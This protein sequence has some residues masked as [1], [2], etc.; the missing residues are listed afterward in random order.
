MR[1][2][3]LSAYDAASHR[4][5]REGLVANFPE[6]EWRVLSLPPRFFSWRIRGNSLSWAMSERPV[7][8]QDYDLL[9]ATS[10]VDLATLRG[11]V[12]KL[13]TMP[14]ILYFHENQFAYPG[15]AHQFSSVEPQM[16]T[17]YAALAAD[18]LAFNS[19]YNRRTFLAGVTDLLGRFPD[20]VPD[21]I[22]DALSRRSTVVP[23]PLQDE[24]FV[25][26][27]TDDR[28]RLVDDRLHLIWNHRWEYDKGPD[29]LLA[30]V[31]RLIERGIGFELSV[32]G[33]RF[34]REPEAFAALRQLLDAH[35]NVLRHWGFMESTDE[36]RD[37]LQTGDV[38][39]STALHDF[40]GLSVL[41]AV[42]AGCVPLVPDRLCYPEWFDEGFRYPSLLDDINAEADAVADAIERLVQQKLAQQLPPPPDL[43]EFSWSSL[44]P[45]YA[46]LMMVPGT[47]R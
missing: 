27:I 5:W 43:N 44:A 16:V 24:C 47:D 4:R 20:E 38:V 21:G 42:A 40:Q 32:L 29:R 41:E 46:D 10:M 2:L 17:L 34:R 25:A 31:E 33:E 22:V 1:I 13:A 12:P 18:R 11:L 45:R 14:S 39:I 28:D 19:D 35:L 37:H 8:E 15:S 36:Y 7:L 6:H 3:L 9:V 30:V 26:A 23:V